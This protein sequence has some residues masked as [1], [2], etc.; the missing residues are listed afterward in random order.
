M[1]DSK[2]W[3]QTLVVGVLLLIVGVALMIT[4]FPFFKGIAINRETLEDGT[5]VL[6]YGH[7]PLSLLKGIGIGV[8]SLSGVLILVNF[9]KE[10]LQAK[11]QKTISLFS[12]LGMGFILIYFISMLIVFPLTVGDVNMDK[13]NYHAWSVSLAGS[14]LSLSMF[15]LWLFSFI[16]KTQQ[17]VNLNIQLISEG[18]ICV[19][20]AIVLSVL[21]DLIPGLKMPNGGSFSLSMLPLFVFALRR[22]VVPGAL[23]GFTYG[24]ANFL[25]DGLIIHWGS[26]FFDYFMP[27]TLLGAIGGVFMKKANKGVIGYSVVAVVMGSFVRYLF[28]GLSGMI[29][30]AEY[31]PDGMS[32]FYYSF[33]FYNLPYMVVST[34][35]ALLFVVLLHK[36]LIT[37]DTRIV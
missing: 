8:L 28:H 36:R 6:V 31:T 5:K 26:I 32:A 13:Y 16:A 3:V 10:I 15:S 29:F 23:V 18:A 35:G 17:A 2:N 22:G 21:S 9:L 1:N 37:L 24:I 33:I 19:A 25:I 27:F 11:H 30:F 12:L 14:I 20:L 7:H 34:I 4:L